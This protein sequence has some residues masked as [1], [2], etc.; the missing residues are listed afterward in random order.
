MYKKIILFAIV[1]F[2]IVSC[3][4]TF[5]PGATNA[6]KVSNEWWVNYYVDGVDQYKTVKLVTYNTAANNDSI[7]VDDYGTFWDYKVRLKADLTN[8]TF[9]VAEGQNVS[10]DSK[11]TI[12]DGKIMPKAAKSPTGLVTDSIYFKV[13]FDDETDAQGNPTPYATTFEV[14]GYARTG[15][16]EDDH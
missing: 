6:K 15:W 7:W 10:Y 9:A 2:T 5:D 12:T 16:A 4:K 11:V 14:K 1:L 8:L 3:E 13:A